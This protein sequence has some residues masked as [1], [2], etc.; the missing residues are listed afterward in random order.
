LTVPSS[1]DVTSHL[2]SQWNA[3]PVMFDVWP[4][5]VRM[6]FGFVDLMS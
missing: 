2:L 4:S 5:N 1:D 3:T 6:A